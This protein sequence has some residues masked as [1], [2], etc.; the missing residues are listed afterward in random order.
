MSDRARLEQRIGR[1]AARAAVSGR[2]SVVTLAVPADDAD[3][4]AIALEGGPPFAYWE[5]PER[6]FAIAASGEA[7][8]IVTP[9]GAERFDVASAALRELG[10]RT[11]QVAFGGAERAPLLIGGFSFAS[12]S[13]WP[14]FPAGRLVLPELVYIRRGPGNRVWMAAT[15]VH[16]GADP[17]GVADLLME[18][19]EVARRSPLEPV[20]PRV[21][22]RR[23]A[24]AMDLHDPVFLAN[25]A[26]AIRLIDGGGLTKVTLARRLDVDHRPDLG[27]FLAALR[28]IHGACTIFAFV[29]PGGA[30]FCGAT[31]ELLAGIE[32]LEVRALALA[33]TAPRGSS[34]PEDQRLADRLL[35]DPKELE[36]H[37]HVRSELIRRLSGGGFALGSPEQTGVLKLP[38]I[39]HLA[40]PIN[41]VAPVGT[42]VLD[43]VGSL[44]PTP[45]VGGLPVDEAMDWIAAREPFDRGWY[46]G[47]IGFCDL[48][49][50]GRF[51]AALRSCLIE[52]NRTSLF[53][54]AG[55]VSASTPEGEL[56]E[57]D[58]KLG[59][60]LPSL[61]GMTD[62]RWRSYATADALVAALVEGGVARVIISPGSRSTALALAVSDGGP[63]SK[64]VLD[65]R[66]AGFVALGLARA[67]GR[68]AAL[69]CTSG[70]A[71][72]NYLPAVV[73]ADRGRVPLVVIT[74]DRPPGFLDRDAPQTIN[75]I[76]LY[77]SAVRA[78]AYLP[79]AHECDPGWIARETLRV[80]RAA[81]APDAGPVHLNVPFDK[82]L[83]PPAR[84]DTK[85]SFEMS[86]PLAR[87]EPVLESSVETLQGFMDGASRGVIVAGPRQPGPEERDAV[88]QLAARSGWP[89]LAD[90][91]SG[92]RTCDH[93]NLVT[94]GDIL[95]GDRDFVNRNA[96]D[97][98]LRLGGI[99][100]GTATQNWLEALR[101]PELVLDP[102]FRWRAD[103]PV[104]VL[105]D[106]IAALVG[107]VSP[108]PVDGSWTGAWRAAEERVRERRRFER[109]HHPGT[110]LALTAEVLESEPV[111]WA[112]SSLPVR[113]VNAMLEPGCDVVVLGNRGASG[114]DGTLASAAGAALGL[115]RRVTALVGDL[116]FLHDAGSLV[117]ARALG[118]DLSIVVLDNGGGIIFEMLPYLRSLRESGTADDYAR[119]RDLFVTPHDQDL[120]AVAA[121]F[122]VA[123]AQIEPEKLGEALREAR[124]REG[125][126]VLVVKTDPD[127]MFAAYHR[128]YRS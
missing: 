61:S 105:R 68:P 37:G 56:R 53:A 60:L 116:T 46:A 79:V 26:E 25:A 7:Y 22:D 5:H 96:P 90:G 65:E 42:S 70:S 123:A 66:S 104:A 44:H 73:E 125:V 15:E 38:G 20:A 87:A 119:G 48:S 113:H 1:A 64:M 8:T 76:D 77:G 85:P 81:M 98:V 120:A 114:I 6:G 30:V 128:L 72:A 2:S 18:R 52:G 35:S 100:T 126:S 32:G 19:I 47:P 107:C 83:E 40:T 80:L 51:H 89:V 122:G 75:Q 117:T 63:P 49:G 31:P 59:A 78:S 9:S 112:G 88:F 50:N 69:V 74:A 62:H 99:P 16:T 92:L 24:E 11:H 3:P 55:I 39:L 28:Q 71:A 103:G 4:L 93:E 58:L 95:V 115:G 84:R 102:D 10:G 33:G 101:A 118:V 110:E 41:A 108:A 121:G 21:A 14:G 111:V 82:P 23:S 54:G 67:T 12:G 34:V 109:T 27:P 127:A 91:V 29:R 94:A 36:E 43:V 13:T 57:T 106:E 124:S 86:L 45:A 17:M 97:A